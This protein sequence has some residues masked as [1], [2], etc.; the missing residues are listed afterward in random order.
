MPGFAAHTAF[1]PLLAALTMKSAT[2]RP[3]SFEILGIKQYSTTS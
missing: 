2:S 3:D 1:T